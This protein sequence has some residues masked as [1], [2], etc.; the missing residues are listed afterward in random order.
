M[1]SDLFFIAS[2]SFGAAFRVE[3]L[4]ILLLSAGLVSLHR[5]RTRSARRAF[6]VTFVSMLALTVL[7]LGHFM[8]VPVELRYPVN[9]QICAIVA[10]GGQA[11]D[12]RAF[13][14]LQR[15]SGLR[16]KSG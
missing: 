7:P 13:R 9:T 4:F 15:R 5:Q 1:G 6:G 8:L 11:R 16:D 12:D 3:T 2:K 14:D 10:I